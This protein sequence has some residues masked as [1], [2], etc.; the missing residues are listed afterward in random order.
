MYSLAVYSHHHY[1]IPMPVY[2]YKEPDELISEEVV[3]LANL[4]CLQEG[5]SK[6]II[7]A[8]ACVMLQI[9]G[10]F[11]KYPFEWNFSTESPDYSDEL[12]QFCNW[13]DVCTYM[14]IEIC[15]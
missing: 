12:N 2:M 6:Q 4:R 5:F 7:L 3:M 14:H 1:I 9:K 10:N 13:M 15:R 11:I 8:T